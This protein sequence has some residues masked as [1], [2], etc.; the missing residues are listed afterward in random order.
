MITLSSATTN[1][2][3]DA[4]GGA[5]G[6]QG[7]QGEPGPQGEQGIQGPQGDPGPQGL[8]GP[9]GPAGETGPEGPQGPQGEPGTAGADGATG[10]AGPAG[11]TGATGPQ[12]PP[13]DPGPTGPVGPAGADGA[14]GAPGATG[15]T[16]PGVAT[17]GATGQFLRKASGTNFDTVWDTLDSADLPSHTHAATDITGLIAA[18]APRYAIMLADSSNVTT[19]PSTQLTISSVVPGTYL[20]TIDFRFTWNSTSSTRGVDGQLDFTGTYSSLDGSV[21]SVN[22]Q[23]PGNNPTNDMPAMGVSVRFGTANTSMR[24]WGMVSAQLVVTGTG[25]LS[26]SLVTTGDTGIFRRGSIMRLQR[27]A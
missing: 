22:S 19:T 12:G 7:P 6:P 2:I 11:A 20:L 8:Q 16:G 9:T 4:G 3:L 1:V 25:N 13:G 26:L 23:T 15:A 14:D 24:V 17:G 21:T 27:V 5:T 18:V 10:P